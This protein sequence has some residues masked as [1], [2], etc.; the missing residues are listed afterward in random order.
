M[1]ILEYDF[2][3]EYLYDSEH[4]W[5]RN[6]G[7]IVTVGVTDFFQKTANEIVFI[8]IPLVGRTLEKGVP[9]SSIESGKWV[10]RLKAPI[11]G[12]IVAV[13]TELT[14]FPYLLN[15]NPYDDGWIIK[16]KPESPDELDGLY[17][18]KDAAQLKSYEA[19]ISNE[20]QKI[21]EAQ[22]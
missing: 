22:K 9:Y 10:G 19:F 21:I 16:I 1:K 3:D 8:E 6:D 2:A 7:D 11:G 5:L 18:L 12:E 13:N 14:D 17:N 20:H 15:E 4:N